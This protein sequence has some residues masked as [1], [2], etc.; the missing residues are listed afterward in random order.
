[1]HVPDKANAL[2]W[3]I[4]TMEPSDASYVDTSLSCCS[5]TRS[6]SDTIRKIIWIMPLT[7]VF[8]CIHTIQDEMI[9]HAAY[10]RI[11]HRT[12]TIRRD[13]KRFEA[14]LPAAPRDAVWATPR[15]I[16]RV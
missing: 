5:R 7:V 6:Q 16:D 12:G 4:H 9:T 1:M 8:I 13:L 14:L 3:Y 15:G 10:V 2:D 11:A